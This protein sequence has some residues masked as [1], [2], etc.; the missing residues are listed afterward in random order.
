MSQVV[1]NR[2]KGMAIRS[3][4]GRQPWRSPATGALDQRPAGHR[5]IDAGCVLGAWITVRWLETKL[6]GFEGRLVWP[7]LS[8]LVLVL[9]LTQFASLLPARQAAKLDVQKA[10]NNA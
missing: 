9:R 6:T 8:V 1:A 3:G 10:L 2:Q 7:Y 4:A 5:R